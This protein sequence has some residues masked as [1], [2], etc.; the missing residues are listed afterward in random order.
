MG[1]MPVL[2][3]DGWQLFRAEYLSLQRSNF[4]GT[5]TGTGT[6]GTVHVHCTLHYIVQGDRQAVTWLLR[7]ECMIC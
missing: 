4:S 7:A 1:S 6:T 3:T 2:C 5:G